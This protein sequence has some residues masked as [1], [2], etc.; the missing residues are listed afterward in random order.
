M[1]GM[2]AAMQT[3]G[4]LVAHPLRGNQI[5]SF[6]FLIAGPTLLIV[7][8]TYTVLTRPG[9][10]DA[11]IGILF[12]EVLW[13]LALIFGVFLISTRAELTSTQIKR[14]TAYGQRVLQI[15]DVTSALLTSGGRGSLSWPSGRPTRGFCYQ[16]RPSQMHSY[17]RCRNS[18]ASEPRRLADRFKPRY[19]RPLP[20]RSKWRLRSTSVFSSSR[21]FS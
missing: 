9:S 4:S 12:L 20:D 18:F 15:S 2:P 10:R 1:A 13:L 21:W 17:E 16:T 3:A 7:S 14:T 19:R 6:I 11:A 5:C 8:L